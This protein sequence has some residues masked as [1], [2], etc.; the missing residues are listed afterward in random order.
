MVHDVF[1]ALLL[2]LHYIGVV[3]IA[4]WLT[5]RLLRTEKGTL[6]FLVLPVHTSRDVQNRLYAQH[7]RRELL[8]ERERSV[9]VALDTGLSEPQKKE[10]LRFCS[11]VPRTFCCTAEELPALMKQVQNDLRK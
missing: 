6:T 10:L 9:I 4:Y 2:A 11:S 5:L 8:C 7:L 1:L 3:A